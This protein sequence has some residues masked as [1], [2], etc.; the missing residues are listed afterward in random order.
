MQFIK[1]AM[2]VVFVLEKMKLLLYMSGNKRTAL[3][4]VLSFLKKVVCVIHK[5]H[6]LCLIS[7]A[8]IST[9]ALK[10]I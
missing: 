5:N 7:T 10:G 2:K 6:I 4:Q 8:Y 3:Q 9:M 1:T